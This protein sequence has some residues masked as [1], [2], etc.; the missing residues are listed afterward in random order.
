M[1]RIILTRT[2]SHGNEWRITMPK[3]VLGISDLELDHWYY[4]D[5]GAFVRPGME[6]KFIEQAMKQGHSVTTKLSRS[7]T[8]RHAWKYAINEQ[9]FRGTYTQWRR[10][11]KAERAE[12][13]YG[14]GRR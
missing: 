7:E 5:K 3:Q 8:E 11:P 9:G 10:L 13:E 4:C 12:Y 6:T 14:A 2:P 1:A